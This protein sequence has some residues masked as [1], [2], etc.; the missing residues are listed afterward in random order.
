MSAVPPLR[1]RPLNRAQIRSDGDYVLY[2][3][4]ATRRLRWNYALDRAVGHAETLSKP[5]VVLEAVSGSKL[6]N[7]VIPVGVSALLHL[8]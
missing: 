5:L 8:L 3:M 2:W 4:T 1:V 6:D 7:L